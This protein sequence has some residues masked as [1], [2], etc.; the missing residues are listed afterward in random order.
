MRARELCAGVQAGEIV[1]FDKGYIDFA[2]LR[3]LDARGV[4]WVTRAKT[5]LSYEVV[6]KLPIGGALCVN[7]GW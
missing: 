2:H 3:D 6:Q 5:N 4:F 7:S 1:I